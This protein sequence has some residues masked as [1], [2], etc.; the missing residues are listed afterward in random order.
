MPSVRL[1]RLSFAYADSVPILSDVDLLLPSGFTALVGENGAGKSTLLALLAGALSPGEGRVRLEGAT[2]ALCPQE[3]HRPGDEL[4]ALAGREDGEARRLRASL[5]LDPGD[6][7]RWETLSPGERK[8]WQLAGALA[9]EPEVLLLDEPT[10][11]ADADARALLVAALRRFRGVGVVVSHDRALLEAI[12][13]RT[14][15]LHRGEARLWPLPYGA[16]RAAWEAELRAAWDRRGAAQD[17]A[18]RAA[19]KLDEARRER[20]AAERAMSGR[21]RDPKDS[22]ARTLGAKTLRAWAEDRLGRDVNR[23]RAAAERADDAVANAL[24]AAALGGAI[25]LGF[26]RAPRPVLL[27]LDAD[28]VRAGAMPVLRDVHVR[29][30]RE[31]RVR[32]EGPNG[33]GK[34]TLVEALL[35]GST[36]PPEKLLHLPQELP[37]GAG[38]RLLEE[39]RALAPETK[40]RVLSLVAALGSDPGRL[41]ASRDPSPGEAR[42]LLLALGLG[43]HA[44]A[45]V[46]DEPTNHL[47]LP[48]VER[49]E[50]ALEAYPGAILLVTHDDAFAARVLGERADAPGGDPRA[51][52]WRIAE[53]RVAP[54]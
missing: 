41:L 17:A 8:R 23:L 11:H 27:S 39:V 14:L 24:P 3:V 26:E 12:A 1:E 52:R 4:F 32:V 51:E 10:N 50:A 38:A 6:L 45:L 35:G 16:A 36:L 19:R 47:D 2:V 48:T 22:D 33:A 13:P 53:G 40:G 54:A 30:G 31:A 20:E 49:L 25:S 7:A 44:W 28:V 18:R 46:L 42:K 5:A 29:L 15:R 34:T 43:R 37:A 9:A 21:R